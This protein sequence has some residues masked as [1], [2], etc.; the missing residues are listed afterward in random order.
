MTFK[1][2]VIE[3]VKNIPEG[4]TLSYGKVA[5]LAGSKGAARAVG[6]IMKANYDR[7]VPCHRVIKANGEAGEYNRGGESVKEQILEMEK[8]KKDIDHFCKNYCKRC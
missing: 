6:S 4:E 2:R 7:S 5:E 1:E 3:I 8:C